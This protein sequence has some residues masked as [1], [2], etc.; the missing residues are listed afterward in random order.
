MAATT[1]PETFEECASSTHYI[2]ATPEK[3]TAQPIQ[4]IK[5]SSK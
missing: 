5:Y 3:N 4:E 2:K 1:S